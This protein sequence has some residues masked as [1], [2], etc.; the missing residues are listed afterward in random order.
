[1][2]RSASTSSASSSATASSRSLSRFALE[3]AERAGRTPDEAARTAADRI[4]GAGASRPIKLGP[5]EL[6]ALAAV[7][8]AWELE[9]ESGRRLREALAQ[10][11]A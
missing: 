8:D 4:R 11:L 10:V 9:A 3:L 7:I 6:V 1:M 5:E 2:C